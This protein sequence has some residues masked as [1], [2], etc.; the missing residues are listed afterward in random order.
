MGLTSDKGTFPYRGVIDFIDNQVK[1]GTGTIAVRAK[2]PNPIVKGNRVLTPGLFCKVRIDMGQPQ[3][4]LL[5]AERCLMLNQ[6]QR[7]VYVLNAKNEVVYRSIEVGRLDNGLRVVLKGV[8]KEDRVMV[9]G[10]QGVRPGM[11]CQPETVDMPRITEG[12]ADKNDPK[13][14]V[15]KK[16]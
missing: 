16:V 6:G 8:T 9:N 13:V 4:R 7:Y 12:P 15:Q 14:G 5:V 11:V 3:Q 2:F 1:Q 10:M